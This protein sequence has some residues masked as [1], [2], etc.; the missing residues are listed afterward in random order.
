M[1]DLLGRVG[2]VEEAKNLIEEMSMQP[3]AIV[4]GSLLAACKVHRNIQL[5]EYV[6][7][8]LLEVDPENS[9]PYVLLSNM[10]AENRDWKN[11]VRV[12]KLMRQRGVIKQPG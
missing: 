9:R 5:G 3:D 6:V 7:E 10:Y 11:V 8:K 4:W 12:R 2:Y 1:V